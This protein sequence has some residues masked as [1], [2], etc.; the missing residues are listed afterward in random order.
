MQL[1]LRCQQNLESNL[2]CHPVDR[3]KQINFKLSLSPNR[4]LSPSKYLQY[5]A[6]ES[7][8]IL[9]V[10]PPEEVSHAEVLDEE[11]RHLR[12]QLKT[13]GILLVCS[14]VSKRNKTPIQ[15]NEQGIPS[16]PA[17]PLLRLEYVNSK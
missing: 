1:L 14:G 15:H 6:S 9:V 11:R 5:P 2:I 7:C 16:V 12:R 13:K 3:V 8:V 10:L 4:Y 17:F